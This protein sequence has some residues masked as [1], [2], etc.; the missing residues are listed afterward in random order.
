MAEIDSKTISQIVLIYG[1]FLIFT[2]T[3][4]ID[5]ENKG[6]LDDYGNYTLNEV[7]IPERTNTTNLIDSRIEELREEQDNLDN[8]NWDTLLF[9]VQKLLGF[10][11]IFFNLMASLFSMITT[12]LSLAGISNLLI[13]SF[14]R[15]LDGI[16]VIY[17]LSIYMDRVFR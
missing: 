16:L 13:I 1:I 3:L 6:L 17:V 12:L 5:M 11:N 9:I 2:T 10:I 4:L 14:A 8:T 15:I 7:L